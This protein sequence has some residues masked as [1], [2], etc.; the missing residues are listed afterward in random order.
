MSDYYSA[1]KNRIDLYFTMIPFDLSEDEDDMS[2]A[3]TIKWLSE[4]YNIPITVIRS[5]ICSILMAYKKY[6]DYL[7]IYPQ[8]ID[9]EYVDLKEVASAI[10]EGQ[11]DDLSLVTSI[12]LH[13][14][15]HSLS[16][17]PEEQKA[18]L[19]EFKFST[20]TVDF[21]IKKDFKYYAAPKDL[22]N[23]LEEINYAIDN[24]HQICFSYFKG[25]TPSTH[26]L[27][28]VKIIYDNEENLYYVLAFQDKTFKT[29]DL[30]LI[31]YLT[32]ETSTKAE[33]YDKE[34]LL[35]KAPHVWKNAFDVKKPT[36]VK[37]KFNA[38]V[39]NRIYEDLAYRNPDTLLTLGRDS[40]IIFED[41]IYGLS[42]FEA[43]IRTYGSNA[44]ILEPKKLAR[45][46]IQKIKE[47]LENYK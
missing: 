18:L 31:K 16:L 17:S 38:N 34:S 23:T 39:Y 10:S 11:W 9:W 2:E 42:G 8:D 37:V 1:P 28:P 35:A 13:D 20:T 21:E 3:L 41:D 4:S 27:T 24:N 14:D 45:E 7:V 46:R 33:D 15:C 5:D 26:Q 22:F 40:S 29:F 47:T 44:V 12:G 25:K 36:H 6:N 19:E 43:W 32:V 30:R